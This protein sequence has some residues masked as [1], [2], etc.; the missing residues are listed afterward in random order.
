MN[1]ATANGFVAILKVIEDNVVASSEQC[2]WMRQCLDDQHHVDRLPRH[3][4]SSISYRGTTGTIDGIA[5]DCGVLTGPG[6]K[7]A[8]AVL[9]EGFDNRHDAER[10]TGRIGTVAAELVKPAG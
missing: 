10:M 1:R 7:I 5:H 2:A 3:L 4:P 8:L 6:G 9:T